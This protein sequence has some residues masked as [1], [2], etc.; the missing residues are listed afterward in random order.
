M[1]PRR[2]T[3]SHGRGTS[4]ET[5]RREVFHLDK[6][7]LTFDCENSQLR[8][9]FPSQRFAISEERFKCPFSIFYENIQMAVKALSARSNLRLTDIPPIS[10]DVPDRLI[11]KNAD[12]FLRERRFSTE[13]FW[14]NRRI[15]KGDSSRF[16]VAQRKR[17]LQIYRLLHHF[18]IESFNCWPILPEFSDR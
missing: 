16:E 5:S 15:S 3:A 2:A 4:R 12:A 14:R 1:G 17:D 10:G 13:G 8:N 6:R 7:N 18:Q 9:C 11:Q